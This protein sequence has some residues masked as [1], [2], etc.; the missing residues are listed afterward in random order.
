[1][2]S[3]QQF[4]AVIGVLGLLVAA[5]W[6]LKQRGYASG[7]GGFAAG[8]LIG[9]L[10]S[11]NGNRTMQAIERL[12]LSATHSLHLVRVADRAILIATSPAGCQV[13]ESHPWDRMRRVPEAE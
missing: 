11:S 3:F 9:R 5:L 10:R 7:G 4:A 2:E 13:V 8:R 6:W 12:P 1:M